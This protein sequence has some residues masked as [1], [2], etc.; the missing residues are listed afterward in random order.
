MYKSHFNTYLTHNNTLI[1][2]IRHICQFSTE[3]I[4]QKGHEKQFQALCS[5]CLL[6]RGLYKASLK[7]KGCSGITNAGYT[8]CSRDKVCNEYLKKGTLD[9]DNLTITAVSHSHTEAVFVCCSSYHL[10][11][12]NY[13]F[14]KSNNN[15]INI[16]PF[17]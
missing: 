3:L 8:T 5:Q 1:K 13:L 12:Q 10:S 11:I 6:K 9:G 16:L 4:E 7:L 15:K 14:T 2:C 17:R